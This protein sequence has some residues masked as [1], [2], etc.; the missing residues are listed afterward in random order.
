MVVYWARPPACVRPICV[1][2]TVTPLTVALTNAPMD[3]ARITSHALRDGYGRVV[4]VG[5]DGTMLHAAR[6]AAMGGPFEGYQVRIAATPT[7]PVTT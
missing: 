5:G 2:V 7:S 6:M 1:C 3:A 4:A